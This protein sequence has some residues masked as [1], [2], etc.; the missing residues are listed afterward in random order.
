MSNSFKDPFLYIRQV[1]CVEFHKYW[2]A[3]NFVSY[4]A[5]FTFYHYVIFSNSITRTGRSSH[6]YLAM[7]NFSRQWSIS[8]WQHIAYGICRQAATTHH[9]KIDNF[10][11]LYHLNSNISCA[12]YFKHLICI[13]FHIY[14][15]KKEIIRR[16]LLQFCKQIRWKNITI[17]F[18]VEMKFLNEYYFHV[19]LWCYI[20]IL[21]K[22]AKSIFL[23]KLFL[24]IVAGVRI[25][26]KFT[27]DTF[28]KRNFTKPV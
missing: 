20:A 16:H 14:L 4:V 6:F 23:L 9:M 15:N 18:I 12:L 22:D 27:I 13:W 28:T 10:V 25:N 1:N 24:T 2:V 11:P 19:I 26:C 8:K 17:A 5:C 3:D 21:K 7:M